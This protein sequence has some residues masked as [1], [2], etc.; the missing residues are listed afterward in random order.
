MCDVFSERWLAAI[1]PFWNHK[2]TM[3]ILGGAYLKDHDDRRCR[4]ML[5]FLDSVAMFPRWA[6]R[7]EHGGVA[8]GGSSGP[9]VDP[10]VG[11]VPVHPY[12]I[13]GD[14]HAK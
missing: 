7:A 11:Y 14:A 10:L 6:P 2:K 5:F 8:V 4:L 1:N 13:C 12:D 9:L 3:A